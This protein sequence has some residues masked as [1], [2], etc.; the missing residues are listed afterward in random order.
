MVLLTFFL[1]HSFV[2]LAKLLLNTYTDVKYL[3][4]EKFNQDPVEEHFGRH[5]ARGV[6]N[7]TVESY[8]HDE[9]KIIVAKSEMINIAAGNTRGKIK[10]K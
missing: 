7:P 6:E 10:Q 9:K 1:V 2:E 5:R 3:L 8:M 4:S